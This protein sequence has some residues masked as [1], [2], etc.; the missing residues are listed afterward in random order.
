MG[1]RPHPGCPDLVHRLPHADGIDRGR[2]GKRT[3]HDRNVVATAFRVRHI[4]E[5]EGPPLVLGNAANE[6]PSHQRMQLGVLVDGSIDA[7]QQTI[8]FQVGEVLLEIEPRPAATGQSKRMQA[9]GLIEHLVA[10]SRF[11]QHGAADPSTIPPWCHRLL[12]LTP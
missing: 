5:H 7:H 11:H 8:G 4:G 12:D 9:R 6:L 1:D 10:W 2:G 3:D